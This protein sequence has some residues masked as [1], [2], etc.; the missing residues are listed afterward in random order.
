MARGDR[1]GGP[2][3]G[4]VTVAVGRVGD[5]DT[6]CNSDEAAAGAEEG[7]GFAAGEEDMMRGDQG[8][9]SSENVYF[10]ARGNLC[11]VGAAISI[12]NPEKALKKP[13]NFFPKFFLGL[14]GLF[15]LYGIFDAV[16]PGGGG[17]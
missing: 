17:V 13:R 2:S 9:E 1:A 5:T 4:G 8:A 3:S 7:E 12:S 6:A 11:Q 14:L 16:L 10:R 15:G